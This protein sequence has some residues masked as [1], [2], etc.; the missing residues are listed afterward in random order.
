MGG[1]EIGSIGWKEAGVAS[2]SIVCGRLQPSF[3]R[4]IVAMA[5]KLLIELWRL[6]T[7]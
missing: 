6:V 7:R 1:W 5:R 3:R 4:L 2:V